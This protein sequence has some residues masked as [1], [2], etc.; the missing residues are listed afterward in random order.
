MDPIPPQP[1]SKCDPRNFVGRGDVTER[2]ERRLS[3]GTNLLLTDPRR[4]G[5]SSWITHFCATTK[6]F[7]PVYIDYQ[8]VRS[9][10]E[11]LVRTAEAL[12]REANIPGRARR[13]LGA[14][15]DNI[16]LEEVKVGPVAVKVGVRSMSATAL[17]TNVVMSVNEHA[18]DRPVLVCMD[19]V[20]WAVRNISVDES[21]Q[22][23]SELLQTLRTLRQNAANLRWLLCG[24]IGFHHVLRQSNA[25][26]G[27][28][29]DL[30]KLK[31]GP[32]RGKEALELAH[33]LLLG[34]RREPS[35]EAVSAL[36][37]T[38]DGIPFL[39]HKVASLIEENDSSGLVDAAEVERTF[40]DFVE[41]RDGSMAATHLLERLDTN[42]G[43]NTDLARSLLDIVA[44]AIDTVPFDALV[45]AH[46]HERIR[47]VVDSLVDDHY[48]VDARDTEG[49]S[50][51]SWRYLVLREIWIRRRRLQ[52]ARP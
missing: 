19:E 29:N 43:L 13:A 38:C 23:A 6:L 16:G 22:A 50:L 20:P 9:C 15:F 3:R 37:A 24:S 34:A 18:V 30:D 11:F 47:S 45:A 40:D 7:S 1:G 5:K 31:F 32:L 17:L 10:E 39:M 2:A 21:A 52:A 28:I 48:L 44:V 14:F 26:V 35:L 27:D 25:T 8:G 49:R 33:R 12:A 46:D 36:A 41:D 42:Y 51:L 4:M